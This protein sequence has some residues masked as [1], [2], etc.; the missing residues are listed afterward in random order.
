MPPEVATFLRALAATDIHPWL[1]GGWATELLSAQIRPHDDTD[2]FV[3]LNDVPRLAPLLSEL[4]FTLVHG[5]LADDAFYRHGELLLNLT[6]I[7]DA[8][9]PPRTLGSLAAIV[10]PS[11]LLAGQAVVW[12]GIPM[13]SLTPA[14]LIAM[15]RCVSEFYNVPLREKDEWD[16]AALGRL[17]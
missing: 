10:W 17:T 12:D 4:G 14:A 11:D 7:D 13:Q 1:M 2:L 9:S 8:V 16:I 3:A 6:P 5:S 15:K